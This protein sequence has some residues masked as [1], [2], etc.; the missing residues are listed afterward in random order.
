MIFFV[1]VILFAITLAFLA[2]RVDQVAE[3]NMH[4]GFG[5]GVKFHGKL[6]KSDLENERPC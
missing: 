5:K 4:I 1:K 3:S 2:W 6:F